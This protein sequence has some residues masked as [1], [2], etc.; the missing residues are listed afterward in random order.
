MRKFISRALL[1][2]A[3]V[4]F[5]CGVG[6]AQQDIPTGGPIP[7]IRG[8]NGKTADA[9][10]VA[11]IKVVVRH[12]AGQVYVIAGA[13]GNVTVFAGDDGIMLVDTNFNVFYDQILADIRRISNKPIRLIINTHAHADHV[14]NN[15]NFAKLGAVVI[16]T[17][18]LRAEMMRNK[19]EAAGL[20]IV[21]SAAPMTLHFNGEE[22]DF[23]PLKPAHTDG[24]AAVYFRGSDVWSFGD[25]YRND[26]PSMG[27][28]GTTQ[29][30]ID[31]YNLELSMTGP[32]T[33]VIPGH[34]QL[35]TRDTLMALR[36]AVTTIHARFIDMV[37]K[38]MTLD[39]IVAARPSKEFDARFSSEALSP[40][41]GNTVARWYGA[42]YKE[43]TKGAKP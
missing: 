34:G 38:G 28:P 16:A 26:Y 8:F 11:K 39:Q 42:M 19:A 21:T 32:N 29:N 37:G 41:T 3:C 31:D 20:P 6:F 14:E 18:N 2:V 1:A 22:V 40:T 5:V 35:S 9:A 7:D 4:L 36:D 33:I 10:S 23:V 25:V 15:A 24:D 13:G 27:E 12:V 43:A 30:F 17:P